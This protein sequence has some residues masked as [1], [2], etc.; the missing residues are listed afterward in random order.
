MRVIVGKK[1]AEQGMVELSL[2]RDKVKLPTPLGEG[3][4]K[5]RELLDKA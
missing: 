4:A 3:T 5:V 1:S 2:R